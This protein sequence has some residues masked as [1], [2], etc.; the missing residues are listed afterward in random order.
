M[1]IKRF[2][3]DFNL[4]STKTTTSIE[5]QCI[6]VNSGCKLPIN[7]E[8]STSFYDLVTQFNQA[9]QEFLPT[10]DVLKQ[11]LKKFGANTRYGYSHQYE[12]DQ[13]SLA[14]EVIN[15]YPSIFPEDWA[16]IY[17]T[18]NG[19]NIRA[20]ASNNLPYADKR[21]KTIEVTSIEEEDL[22]TLMD[23]MGHHHLIVEAFAKFKNEFLFGNGTNV[24]FTKVEGEVFDKLKTFNLTFGNQFFNT[25]DYI[26]MKFRLGVP[27][28]ILYD[29][30]KI[31][32]HDQEITDKQ[33]KIQLIN[34]MHQEI[35]VNNSILPPLYDSKEEIKKLRKKEQK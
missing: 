11:I 13:L 31:I 2:L 10:L 9:Y 16:A 12:N 3:Y 28:E 24:I 20:V 18:K 6:A 14:F 23:I 35:Y 15:P 21:S 5:E 27:L 1:D 32:L 19:E 7:F 17:I 26:E 22:K 4:A 29:E 30:S 34:E 8:N 33:E 25:T